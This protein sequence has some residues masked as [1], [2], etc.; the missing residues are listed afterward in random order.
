MIKLKEVEPPF[1]IM[2][3]LKNIY[4]GVAWPYV[5][6]IFHIGNLVGAYLPPDIFARFHKLKGNRV[7]MVS[8]SDFHGTPITLKAAKEGK[9]PEEIAWRFHKLNKDYLKKFR[10][11]YTLYTSTHTANHRKMV[12]DMFLK[13]LKKGFIKILKTE[14]LYSK[15]SKKFLQDR[16]IEGECPYCHAKGARG[17][18][19]EKCGRVLD[20][21]ELIN[22]ISKLDKSKLIK[23][24]TEN[25]F[26]D[27]SK[28]QDEIKKWLLTQNEMREWVKKEA[29]GWIEEGLRPRAITRDLDYGVPLPIDRI[30]KS[31]RIEN[32][33]NKVFYVW[34]E[35]VIGYLSGAIEYSKKIGKPN[36][37]REFFYNPKAQTYYFVGQDNL[38][39]H[40]INWPAQLLGYDKKINLPTNVFVNKF[41]FLEGQK[42]SKSRGWFIETPYLVKNY[43]IDS[44]RFYLAFNMPEEKELNFT[45]Q[46]FIQINNNVLVATVGNFVHRTLT[47]TQKNFGRE[48]N[49]SFNLLSSE[50]RS[51][52]EKTFRETALGLENGEFQCSL[53]KIVELAAFGNKYLERHQV[54]KLVKKSPERARKIILNS[55]AIVD[56]LRTL[57]YPFLPE[58]MEKLN[59]F[60]RQKKNF[61][62][63][64]EKNQWALPKESKTFNLASKI[65][66]LFSKI[67]EKNIEKEIAKLKR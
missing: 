9:K 2:A 41:L 62:F 10:I 36:F 53:R 38:V 19:C 5:N 59:T 56:A 16:Y 63:R 42:M 61:T 26:L 24:E 60:L 18:Q 66:P 45:W 22:P 11:E 34:F 64:E 27:L 54:W 67:D 29:L 37:W 35:A 32:I 14:Q 6:D 25:Y 65:L 15:K 52:I 43:P 28:L 21:T 47:F 30:P 17:D 8:G 7:L 55:L 4:I 51:Q 23:K 58:S 31:Q 50:I 1:K 40:T 39:F 48:F 49:L 44:I 12:Q 20:A 3:K 57:L 33:E 13:L 46:D